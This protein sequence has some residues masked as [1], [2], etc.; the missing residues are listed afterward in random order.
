MPRRRL[1]PSD[2]GPPTP[3]GAGLGPRPGTHV[4]YRRCEP[5]EPAV[6]E[7]VRRRR[8][9]R[10][11]RSDPPAPETTAPES[12]P[13]AKVE[14]TARIQLSPHGSLVLR[15]PYDRG[16]VDHVRRFEA[17]DRAWVPDERVWIVALHLLD[18][19]RALLADRF[20]SVVEDPAI[21]AFVSSQRKA[22]ERAVLDAVRRE[23]AGADVIDLDAVRRR[24]RGGAA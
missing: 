4:R 19:V 9:A 2:P 24:V 5:Y 23:V 20:V 21:G 12:S 7:E 6:M 15:F 16:A 8:E 3:S 13:A 18:E 1:T 22:E 17:H 14:G 11:A 10:E